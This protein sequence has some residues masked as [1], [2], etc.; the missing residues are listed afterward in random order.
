[1]HPPPSATHERL[2][3]FIAEGMRMSPIDQPLMLLELLA[4][5]APPRRRTWPAGSWE[6]HGGPGSPSTASPPMAMATTA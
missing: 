6:A 2:R 4:A 1:M 3:A 5:A